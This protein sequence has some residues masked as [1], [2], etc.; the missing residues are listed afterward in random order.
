LLNLDPRLSSDCPA[1]LCSADNPGRSAHCCSRFACLFA[2]ASSLPGKK[3]APASIGTGNDKGNGDGTTSA[4]TS[5]VE[6]AGP[7]GDLDAEAAPASSVRKHFS[8]CK[9]T[10]S[11]VLPHYFSIEPSIAFL[12]SC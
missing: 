8:L 11:N 6:L 1:L 7:A 2:T 9:L 12:V 3:A 5:T 4:S 10:K